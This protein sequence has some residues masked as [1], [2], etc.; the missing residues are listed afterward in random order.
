MTWAIS[1]LAVERRPAGVQR[2]T[3]ASHLVSRPTTATRSPSSQAATSLPCTTRAADTAETIHKALGHDI[4]HGRRNNTAR[5]AWWQASWTP[6][7]SDTSHRRGHPRLPGTDLE[8]ARHR[9]RRRRRRH[10][11]PLL[12]KPRALSETRPGASRLHRLRLP[13]RLDLRFL[14]ADGRASRAA[15]TAAW[16]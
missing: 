14:A 2:R 11:L 12:P 16:A 9:Q 5:N 3:P 13:R 7:T 4:H 10:L 1:W 6:R 8:P 15:S